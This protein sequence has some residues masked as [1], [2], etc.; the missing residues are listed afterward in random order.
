MAGVMLVLIVGLVSLAGVESRNSARMVADSRLRG[1]AGQLS[2]LLEGSVPGLEAVVSALAGA[3]DVV[4]HAARP[5]AD[6][7]E[8]ALARLT[9]GAQ[10]PALV[11]TALLD[12]SGRPLVVTGDESA[13]DLAGALPDSAAIG[14]LRTRGGNL[15]YAASAPVLS[16]GTVVGHVVQWRALGANGTNSGLLNELIGSGAQL[17]VGNRDGSV[18]TDLSGIVAGPPVDV[19]AAATTTDYTAIDGERRF[20]FAEPIAG[21]PWQ[22]LVELSYAEVMAPAGAFI[23]RMS[24]LGVLFLMMGLGGVYAA[25]LQVTRPIRE[26]TAAV[27]DVHDGDY[28]RRVD[29]GRGDEIGLLGAA[30]DAMTARVLEGRRT[31]EQQ[32]EARTSE[33][34]HALASLRDS[35]RLL[36]QFLDAIPI[37]ILVVDATGASY[38]ENDECRRIFRGAG[39]D[40]SIVSSLPRFYRAANGEGE[41]PYTEREL[42]VRRALAGESVHVADAAIHRNG[43]PIPIEIWSAPVYEADG[44]IAYAVSV[45]SDITE[46]SAAEREIRA[47]R[48][49]AVASN[50]A[51]SEFL[52]KMSHELRTPLNSIIGFSEILLARTF[53]VLNDKQERHVHNVHASGHYLLGLIN[54]VL[55]LSKVEAGR[56]EISV[57]DLAVGSTIREVLT[58][59]EPQ[60]APRRVDLRMHVPE[61]L[62]RVPADAKRIKQVLQ[63]LVGNAVKF[64]PEG[65]SVTVSARVAAGAL[66]VAVAD[67][68]IGI[69]DVDQD[70]IWHEFEQ[71]RTVDSPS[72]MGTGLG[73]TLVRRFVELHGGKVALE[74]EPGRGSTFSFTLPLTSGRATG[75]H[76]AAGGP[77]EPAVAPNPA[78]GPLVLVVEDEQ[79]ALELLQH[80]LSE[81]GYRVASASS[82]GEALS[83]ARVLRPDAITLDIILPDGHGSEVLAKLRASPETAEIPVVVVSISSKRELGHAFGVEH[84]LVKPVSGEDVVSAVAAVTRS[85]PPV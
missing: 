70:R 72:Q 75:R 83:K 45:Y 8:A 69:A 21:T 3:P 82:C 12:A 80:H 23:L 26:L 27:G 9:P 34:S 4:V 63:N 76:Q 64:T 5:A 46:R 40:D 61:D 14:P 11:T 85:G 53:G 42:P 65:G 28:T 18:W 10:A 66:T 78:R 54:E 44:R 15:E 41:R 73:L 22:V 29:M 36:F 81:A 25:S 30:F 48:E 43:Q 31:L 16:A 84:W 67:T 79:G 50:R 55:D 56:M 17:F 37:G 71:V 19:L 20:G 38:Y 13:V 2:E 33:L 60:A 59:L 51:K 7:R 24:G 77:A 49:A 1:V 74:S 62:P 58:M 52:A 35:E 6:T 57:G 47:A 68:G 32:V 39:G